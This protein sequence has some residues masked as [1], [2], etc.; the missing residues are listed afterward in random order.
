MTAESL[1]FR[2]DQALAE[3]VACPTCDTL[4]R[5][6][7]V[8]P[9]GRARCI[10]CHQVLITPRNSAM[11]RIV[12]LATTSTVLMLAAISFPFL[13]LEARGLTQQS[14]VIDTI[15]AYSQGLMLPLSLAIAALIVVLPLLR[16]L[17]I[18]YTLVPMAIG[19]A[20]AKGAARAFRLAEALKPWAMAEIFIVGVAVALVKVADLAHLTIGPAFWAFVGLVLITVLQDSFMCR[21]TIWRTLEARG[22]RR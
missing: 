4:H 9:G 5:L 14:S 19:F 18:L 20:P 3:M 17:A 13:S 6:P 11:T 16:L 12:M 8:A 2:D 10:R 15:L 1:H 22:S 7:D 21:L